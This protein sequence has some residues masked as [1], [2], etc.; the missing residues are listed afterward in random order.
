MDLYLK[1]PTEYDV[2]EALDQADIAYKDGAGTLF[3]AE[4]FLIDDIGPITKWDT[5][6]EPPV[7][8]HYPEWHVN[9]RCGELTEEQ[10]ALLVDCTITP[11]DVPY[12]VWA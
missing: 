1:A 8:L 3:V 12:R 5:S 11:P 4:G 2:Y 6:V 10:T 7:E 9:V